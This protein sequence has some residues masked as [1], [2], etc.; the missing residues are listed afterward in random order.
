M[1]APTWLRLILQAAFAGCL[2]WLQGCNPKSMLPPPNG[3]LALPP[4]PL[5][6]LPPPAPLPTLILPPVPSLPPPA[7]LVPPPPV[8]PAATPAPGSAVLAAPPPGSTPRLIVKN[9]CPNLEMWIASSGN[10]AGPRNVKIPPNGEHKYYIPDAGLSSTRFWPKLWCNEMGQN[11]VMGSSGGDG[12]DC[13]QAG[14]APPIDSKFEASFG[15]K[16][17]DCAKDNKGCDWWDTSAVDGYSLPYR[18]EISSECPQGKDIDCRGLS[19]SQCPSNEYLGSKIG[20][21]DLQV[22]EPATKKV[23]GCYSPCGKLSYSNWLNPVGKNAPDS[24]IAKMYCCPTPP[25]S[26]EDCRTGPVE[27]TAYVKLI[28]QNCPSV[29]GY[30]YD[31]AVGLQVCP[32]GTTY[33]WSIGCPTEPQVFTT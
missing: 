14:C 19:L 13:P 21:Q 28:H 23:V 3:T 8:T 9:V 31:D 24:E 12:Q 25:V 32:S 2:L 29:Y 17:V 20:Q 10:V 33:T 27:Q 15:V 16:G 5:P 30:A 1:E 26:S 6:T 18:V 22:I 4:P 7:V 11:C